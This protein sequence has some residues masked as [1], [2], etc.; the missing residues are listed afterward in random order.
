VQVD[1]Q[2]GFDIAD[3]SELRM[4]AAVQGRFALDGAMRD[5]VAASFLG[6]EKFFL[7]PARG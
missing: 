7:Q 6:D 4:I 5:R 3:P 1:Q 2:G